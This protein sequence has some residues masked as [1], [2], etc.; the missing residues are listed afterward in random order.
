MVNIIPGPVGSDHQKS[1]VSL[2]AKII[3]VGQDLTDTFKAMLAELPDS[4][5]RP[6]ETSRALAID[7][8]LSSRLLKSLGKGDPIAVVQHI[9]GPDPLRRIL[10]SAAKKGVARQ[11]IEAAQ[12]SVE[13]FVLLIRNETGSRSSL[14]AVI[15]SL[16]PDARAEFEVRRKQAAFKALSELK[17]ASA[18]VNLATFI[19]APSKTPGRLDLILVVGL[20]GLRRWNPQATIRVGMAPR[21]SQS[22]LRKATSLDGQPVIGLEGLSGLR[23]DQFCTAPPSVL[24]LRRISDCGHYI[25]GGNNFSPRAPGDLIYA[26]AYFADGV[27]HAHKTPG[28]K[29]GTTAQAPVPCKLQIHDVL[30]HPDL[31]KGQMPEFHVTDTAQGGMAPVNDR[32]RDIDRW[33]LLESV[34]SMGTGLSHFRASEIPHY[35]DLLRHTFK[36]VGWNG[37]DFRG[38]RARIEFPIYCSQSSITFNTPPTSES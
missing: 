14:S 37:E 31:F 2:E 27:R 26:E 12:K 1:E 25:I 5:V 13:N 32:S 36:S 11:T 29:S 16:L 22:Q 6:Q 34:Q 38:F 10:K 15:A 35:V 21:D 7:P 33:T 3:A 18:D 24:E 28:R 23:L 30:I 9:P 19:I 8:V 4:P 20:L 17:G